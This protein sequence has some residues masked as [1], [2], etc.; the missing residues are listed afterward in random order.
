MKKIKL[1]AGVLAA[2]T[3]FTFL[4]TGNV[5]AKDT[6]KAVEGIKT[7]VSGI[8]D[9]TLNFVSIDQIFGFLTDKTAPNIIRAFKRFA[10]KRN[11]K[12]RKN[13]WL[14]TQKKN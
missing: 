11:D 6:Q 14:K 3:C 2:F 7:I 13:N 4:D 12:K 10:R 1:L 5:K 8:K 9:L